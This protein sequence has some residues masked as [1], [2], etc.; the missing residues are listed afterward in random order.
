MNEQNGEMMRVETDDHKY[1]VVQDAK[2]R[3]TALRYGEE[4]RECVGDNLVFKL[5]ANLDTLRQ[6]PA[7]KLGISGVLVYGHAVLLGK[8]PVHDTCGGLWV[9]PGGG[10]ELFENHDTALMREFEEETGLTVVPHKSSVVEEVISDKSHNVMIFKYVDLING[11]PIQTD[12]TGFPIVKPSQEL[13]EF[14]WCY[15][16]DII[17]MIKSKTISYMTAQALKDIKFI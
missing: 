12:M 5:A 9:T 2:G 10:V 13:V 11:S 6:K 8:R 17:A 3:L 14:G 7:I 1:T 15:A 16:D 4:W